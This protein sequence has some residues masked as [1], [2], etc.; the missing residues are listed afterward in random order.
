[1][2][3]TVTGANEIDQVLRSLGPALSHPILQ[4]AHERAA[5]PLVNAAHLLAPVGRTGNLADSIGVTKPSLKRVNVSGEINVGPRRGGMH[6]G[7][8][9]HLVEYGKTNRDGSRSKPKPFMEPAFERTKDDVLGKINQEIGIVV[10][11][12]MK[13]YIRN[14]G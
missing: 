14:H 11:T 13:R 7:Y 10:Y 1:M 2:T 8:H 9:A 12:T 6:K 5:T 3:A 4:K